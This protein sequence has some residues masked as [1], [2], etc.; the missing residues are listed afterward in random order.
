MGIAQIGLQFPL[1]G[2]TDGT[3]G[4]QV[5]RGR[6]GG[7]GIAVVINGFLA[8]G[9]TLYVITG[10]GTVTAFVMALAVVLAA[11]LIFGHRRGR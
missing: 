4:R 11:V 10:S 9:G 1:H 3:G 5:N 6:R 7:E 2:M 8:G